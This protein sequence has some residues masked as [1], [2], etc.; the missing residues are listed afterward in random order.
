[1][2][3]H[4]VECGKMMPQAMSHMP[5]KCDGCGK[6]VCDDCKASMSMS[7]VRRPT[8]EGVSGFVRLCRDCVKL[9]DAVP[10]EPNRFLE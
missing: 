5:Q 8:K 7:Y 3:D 1:M 9:Y 4:C 2:N 6:Y 10:V